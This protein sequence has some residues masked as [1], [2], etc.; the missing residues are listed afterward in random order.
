MHLGTNVLLS[1]LSSTSMSA[2]IFSPAVSSGNKTP[3]PR[4]CRSLILPAGPDVG[5]KPS[6]HGWRSRFNHSIPQM[7]F[8]ADGGASSLGERWS[9]ST[10]TSTAS[11]SLCARV[12]VWSDSPGADR[13][14]R[15]Q[16]G[17]VMPRGGRRR[18]R[19]NWVAHGP[20]M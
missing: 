19:L 20:P 1:Q 7:G 2:V 15:G 10:G 12:T 3:I 4:E 9:I 11:S 14:S 16:L 8:S 18:S 17:C 5:N 6:E 13:A